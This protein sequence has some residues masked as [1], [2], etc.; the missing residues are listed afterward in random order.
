M[1]QAVKHPIKSEPVWFFTILHLAFNSIQFFVVSIPNW[2]HG[3]ILLLSS[4]TGALATR[5]KVTPAEI[6]EETLKDFK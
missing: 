5:R 3:T 1:H 6:L 4:I 2:M